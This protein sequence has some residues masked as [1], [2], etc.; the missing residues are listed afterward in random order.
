LVSSDYRQSAEFD[1]FWRAL[2]EGKVQLIEQK[3]IGA[4]GKEIWT[5]ASYAPITD[6]T[7]KPSTDNSFIQ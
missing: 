4:N 2:N 3:L 5:Q 7:G 1:L 6:A